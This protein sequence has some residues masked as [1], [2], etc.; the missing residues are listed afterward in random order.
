[1]AENRPNPKLPTDWQYRQFVSWCMG[2]LP[3][4]R[5]VGRVAQDL[6]DYHRLACTRGDAPF[7]TVAGVSRRRG[8]SNRT[9]SRAVLL[10]LSAI[11]GSPLRLGTYNEHSHKW[12]FWIVW[13]GSWSKAV[14][15][16]RPRETGSDVK[17][18]RQRQNAHARRQLIAKHQTASLDRLHRQVELIRSAQQRG[19]DWISANAELAARPSTDPAEAAR[20][21]ALNARLEAARARLGIG[22]PGGP[23]GPPPASG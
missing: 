9:A 11:P 6:A 22:K 21:Q 4:R 16:A 2:V 10:E 7:L 23:S 14:N 15:V 19:K 18:W 13:D 1:M 5:C 17:T 3:H 20:I 8:V 12:R